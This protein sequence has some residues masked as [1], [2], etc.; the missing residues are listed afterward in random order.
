MPATTGTLRLE[1]PEDQVDFKR[2]RFRFF[3][4]LAFAMFVALSAFAQRQQTGVSI[5][6]A[7]PLPAV[8]VP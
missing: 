4:F 5:L 6:R 7:G 8:N 2:W 1:T 3:V